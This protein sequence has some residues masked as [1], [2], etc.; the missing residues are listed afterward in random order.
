MYAVS[1]K[2]YTVKKV[3]N[4]CVVCVKLLKGTV[5]QKLTGVESGINRKVFLHIEPLL[6]YFYI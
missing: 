6:F 4:H 5:Q 3:H 2:V 1:H